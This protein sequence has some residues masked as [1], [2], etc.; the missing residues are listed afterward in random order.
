MRATTK[1]FSREASQ[2]IAY[3]LAQMNKQDTKKALRDI[4]KVTQDNQWN[5]IE[6]QLK[7]VLTAL[8]TQHWISLN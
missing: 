1:T 6:Y 5:H 3:Q 4:K 7:D 2:F 8:L